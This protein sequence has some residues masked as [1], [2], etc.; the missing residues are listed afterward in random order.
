MIGQKHE[1]NQ[2][3]KD[4]QPAFK[5]LGVLKDLRNARITKKFGFTCAYL[6]QV[7]FVLIFHHRNWFQLLECTRGESFAGKD[8]KYRFLNHAGFAWRRFLLFLSADT[9]K[10]VNALTSDD[11]VKVFVVANSMYARNRSKAVELL[12]RFWDHAE[13]CYYKGFRMLTLAWSDGHT[14]I[15]VDLVYPLD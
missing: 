8:A 12:A 14:L 4:I 3:P 10:K 7:V 11:R 6:F 1:K 15:P 13:N 2:L 9:V 5:E